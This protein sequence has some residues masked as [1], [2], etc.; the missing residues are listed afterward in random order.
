MYNSHFNSL[1]VCLWN[2]SSTETNAT[3]SS[4]SSH[5]LNIFLGLCLRDKTPVGIQDMRYII[6]NSFLFHTLTC[7]QVYALKGKVLVS[8]ISFQQWS[9]FTRNKPGKKVLATPIYSIETLF[10]SNYYSSFGVHIDLFYFIILN[11]V[12]LIYLPKTGR[13]SN[14]FS[15]IPLFCLTRSIWTIEIISLFA[16]LPFNQ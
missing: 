10:H 1:L 13:R 8:Q 4:A 9:P 14:I 3:S 5:Y 7:W 6:R 11:E 15:H 12:R 2:I 16:L